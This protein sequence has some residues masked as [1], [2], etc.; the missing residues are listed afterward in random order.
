MP[1]CLSHDSGG[2]ETP[3]T[4]A[5]ALYFRPLY[6]SL[7]VIPTTVCKQRANTH[8]TEASLK[9]KLFGKAPTPYPP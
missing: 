6:H 4:K 5:E 8:G 9:M 1:L 7:D 2:G 3:H